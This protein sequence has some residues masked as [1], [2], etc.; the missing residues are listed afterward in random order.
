MNKDEK[1]I[2]KL[3]DEKLQE[4]IGWK[5]YDAQQEI[6]DAYDSGAKDIRLVCGVRWGKTMLVAY[7]ALREWL[8][9]D[10]H[11]WIVAPNYDL[12]KKVF[13]YIKIW[14]E[15]AFPKSSKFISKNPVPRI[16]NPKK[17]SWIECKSAD[18]KKSLSGEE[19][20]LAIGDE[21]AW[22][23][24][25]VHQRYLRARVSSRE[26]KTVYIS[27][28]RGQNWFYDD[29]LRC[30][31]KSNGYAVR[32]PSKSS[33]YFK[34]EWW[35]DI[36]EELPTDIFN[37]EYRAQF[38]EN[39]ASVFPNEDIRKITNEDCLSD[40]KKDRRYV[41]GVDLAKYR[42]WTVVT[43]IDKY[44]H[45]VVYW[46]RW[47]K[48]NWSYTKDKIAEL[49]KRYNHCKVYIDSTGVGDP[50]SDELSE[51]KVLT[52]NFN[53]SGKNKEQL[54]KKLRLYIENHS[55][56]IPPVDELITELQSYSKRMTSKN[57]G[58]MLKN[59]YYSAPEGM[60]DDAVESLALA[61]WGLTSSKRRNPKKLVNTQKTKKKLSQNYR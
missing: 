14:I 61:V 33:P 26:G 13:N 53:F 47:Q 3:S 31:Q 32:K 40:P 30:K 48:E 51:K 11:I 54:I 49:S 4:A 55:I 29:F 18:S 56:I 37:Q 15:D 52:E 6:I 60:H 8:K 43:I 10:R 50:I 24:K 16:E 1:E 9:T 38:L 12:S 57:T 59:P 27:T 58:R 34:E 46:D 23:D 19:L 36:R 20:D 45:E 35:E 28:P 44:S 25:D 42:D 21:V 22:W 2:F 41:L 5:P 17:R 39:A 7:L